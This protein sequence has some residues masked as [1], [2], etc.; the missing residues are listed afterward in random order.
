MKGGRVFSD[1]EVFYSESN[2]NPIDLGTKF[3]SF[4][5][6]DTSTFRTGPDFMTNGLAQA[7]RD[8]NITLISQLAVDHAAK[9]VA[10]AQLTEFEQGE[11]RSNDAITTTKLALLTAIGEVTLYQTKHTQEDILLPNTYAPVLDAPDNIETTLLCTEALEA[12]N[13]PPTRLSSRKSQNDCNS[14]TTSSVPSGFLT[15]K[16]MIPHL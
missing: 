15:R 3:T 16:C 1:V 11:P 12:N 6:T 4:E 13:C 14:A 9:K 7:I 2:Q 8:K 5:M 10:R